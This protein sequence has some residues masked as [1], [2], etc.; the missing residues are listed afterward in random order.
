MDGEEGKHTVSAQSCL[1]VDVVS[2]HASRVV[3]EC[4]G[5]FFRGTGGEDFVEE[6]DVVASGGFD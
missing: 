6:I 2:K 5:F 1:M 3:Q 4:C